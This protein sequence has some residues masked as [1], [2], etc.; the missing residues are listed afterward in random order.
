MRSIAI[1]ALASCGQ[2]YDKPGAQP[3]PSSDP[4]ETPTPDPSPSPSPTPSPNP[5]P[6]P[7]PTPPPPTAAKSEPAGSDAQRF[8]AA[9]NAARAK[10]C[11]PPLVWSKKLAAIAQNWANTLRDKGCVFGHSGGQQYGENLA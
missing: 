6:R 2:M 1:L 8:V 11:A 5:S 10:H 9:H 3:L 4:V 7:V